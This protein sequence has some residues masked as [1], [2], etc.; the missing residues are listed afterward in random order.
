MIDCVQTV[1]EAVILFSFLWRP[2]TFLRRFL[3]AGAMGANVR[4]THTLTSSKVRCMDFFALIQST[5]T[6][7]GLIPAWSI[8]IIA[9]GSFLAGFVDSIAGGGG[10]ISLPAYAATGLPLHF[11]IGTNKL[12]SAMGTIVA[13][14]KYARSGYMLAWLCAPCV[15]A[16]LVGSDIGAHLSLLASEDFLRIFMLI[17]IPIAGFYVLRHKELGEADADWP[18]KKTLALCLAISLFI[19]AYDGFYGPG[20]GTFLMLL[21]TSVGGLGANHAAGVTKCANLTTNLTALV[22]F[23][24]NGTCLFVLG[25]L[26][27]IFNML[28]NYLGST[29]FTEK[30]NTVVRPI[31]LIVLVLFAAKLIFE[32]MA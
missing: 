7:D 4:G 12:A 18:R 2:A 21:L 31:M 32:L 3:P 11:A 13:T 26:G 8:L 30:G 5:L 16:A 20:T 28:G 22:V 29:Q 10:L 17:I 23:A 25:I 9:G 19:G 15:V 27:G 24:V 6:A 1:V 14:I